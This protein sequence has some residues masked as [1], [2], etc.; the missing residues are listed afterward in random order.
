M[1]EDIKKLEEKINLLIKNYDCNK[2][3]D[4]LRV[5]IIILILEYE[6]NSLSINDFKKLNID[7]EF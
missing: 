5:E 2:N 3:K 4:L 6:K 7:G 1:I